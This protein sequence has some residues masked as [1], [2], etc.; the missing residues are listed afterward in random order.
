[1]G[2]QARQTRTDHAWR[3]T[4]D[5]GKSLVGT[6][7]HRL[8]PRDG[9]Y[10][11]IGD[12]KSGDAMMPFYRKDLFA[13]AKE[14]TKGYSWVYTMD[15]RFKGWTKEHQLI[16]EWVTSRKLDEDE[17]V[18]HVN[19]VKTDNRPENLRIM[20]KSEHSSYHATLN[21]TKKWAPENNVWIEE[22]KRN[23]STWMK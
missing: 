8:M 19:F 4:F 23:H 13:G 9:T 22:F 11:E 20:T 16:A 15:D 14:G 7:N 17:C 18:H 10:R 21:N 5:N 3:V 2:K 1:M 6:S 12:L